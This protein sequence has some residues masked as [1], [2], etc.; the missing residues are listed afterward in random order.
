MTTTTGLANELHLP[1]VC[2]PFAPPPSRPAPDP[3]ELDLPVGRIGSARLG[4]QSSDCMGPEIWTS[5]SRPGTSWAGLGEIF[6]AARDGRPNQVLI[7]PAS[8]SQIK[9]NR[10]GSQVHVAALFRS[11]PGLD[12]GPAFPVLY[13]FC[14]TQRSSFRRRTLATLSRLEG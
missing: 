4:K 8:W 2:A 10:M 7:K 5:L 9:A 12:L 13:C 1:R 14:C 6:P 3:T 11:R